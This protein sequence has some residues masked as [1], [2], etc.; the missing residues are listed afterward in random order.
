MKVDVAAVPADVGQIL[1]PVK[2]AVAVTRDVT[3]ALNFSGSIDAFRRTAIAPAVMGSRVLSINVEEGQAV[4][5]NQLLAKMEDFQLRQSEAQLGQLEA[6]YNRMAALYSR[7]SATQQQYEQV[8]TSYVA[9]RAQYE[10]LQNSVELRAP[11]SGTIIGRHIN[12]GEVYTGSPGIGGVSGVLSVAQLGRM[13]IEVMAPEQDFV[14]LRPGQIARVRVDAFPDTI[15]EG[16]V[17]TVN[18]SLNGSSRTSRVAIEIMNERQLLKPGMFA[19]VEI[20]TDTRENVLAVPA[21]AIVMRDGEP[22]V[23]TVENNTA[24]FITTPTLVRVKTGVITDRYAQILEGIDENTV[25]LTD[26]NTSLLNDTG[27]RVTS[28][29]R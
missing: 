23:F 14:H 7:G 13:K 29:E 26:N 2:A 9:A 4:R 12:E 19:R 15:F 25:V 20:I 1:M 16:K 8:R 22:H 24:P 28:V 21:T 5:E 3:Q 27:I 11:F 6:D 18:P 17:F 10:M